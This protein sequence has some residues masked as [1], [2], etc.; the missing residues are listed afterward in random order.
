MIEASEDSRGA[1]FVLIKKCPP[2]IISIVN[3]PSQQLL[4]ASIP[5]RLAS[6]SL[7]PVKA[8]MVQSSFA[9]SE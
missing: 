3:G 6:G 4:H 5:S 7:V 8:E 1:L 9:S 2:S